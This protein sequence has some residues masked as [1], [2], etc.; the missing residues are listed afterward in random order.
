MHFLS[1]KSTSSFTTLLQKSVK[2]LFSD[3]NAPWDILEANQ[4]RSNYFRQKVLG[5]SPRTSCVPRN[6]HLVS[7]P[8]SKNRPNHFFQV[9]T[10]PQDAPRLLRIFQTIL[11]QKFWVRIQA[12][13]RTSCFPRNM[14][15]VLQPYS[16]NQRN[17]F[18]QVLTTPQDAPRL[19]RIFQTILDQ[20][21]FVR[22][23]IIY[24][25]LYFYYRNS[26]RCNPQKIYVRPPTAAI[27]KPLTSFLPDTS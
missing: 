12:W 2:S 24:Y 10:T 16:K 21:F 25:L 1:P 4:N 9:L 17:H 11:D 6:L 26:N 20:K 15:L 27:R 19:I 23:E 13:P 18:F 5:S 8:C 7:Q 22:T 3:L 14:H